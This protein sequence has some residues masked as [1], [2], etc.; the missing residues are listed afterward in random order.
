M[1][2]VV[3]NILNILTLYDLQFT[4]LVYLLAEIVDFVLGQ[5]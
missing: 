3:S 5:H 4:I 2:T 1:H